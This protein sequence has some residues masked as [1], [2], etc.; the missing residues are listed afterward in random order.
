MNNNEQYEIT[1]DILGHQRAMISPSKSH[2][3][4]QFPDN[5]VIFN[6]NIATVSNGKIWWGDLDITKSTE[7]LLQLRKELNEDI[8]IFSELDMRFENETTPVKEIVTT[9][10]CY[11]KVTEEK[12]PAKQ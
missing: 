9:T 10:K 2:Y 8:F 4:I 7:K 11:Y 3:R 12:E 6:S 5:E 1:W